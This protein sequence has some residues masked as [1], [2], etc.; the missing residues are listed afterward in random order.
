MRLAELIHPITLLLK[1]FQI[2]ALPLVCRGMGLLWVTL[3][4]STVDTGHLK[5]SGVGLMV[6]KTMIP[7]PSKFILISRMKIRGGKY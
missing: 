7:F 3:M 6:L 1:P 2:K 4:V 5:R